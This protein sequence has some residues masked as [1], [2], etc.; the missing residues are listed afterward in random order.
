M[1]LL[2]RDINDKY[3]KLPQVNELRQYL[4]K[5]HENQL[6]RNIIQLSEQDARHE[7]KIEMVIENQRGMQFFGIPLFSKNSLIPI[8]DPSNYQLL[9]GG[10][11]KLIDNNLI[12]F[13]LPDINWEWFWGSW[14]VLMLN[15]VDDQGWAYSKIFFGN[16]HWKGKYY[17]GN[18]VRRRIWIRVRRREVEEYDEDVTG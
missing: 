13:P 5:D 4:T 3:K 16:H 12:N 17:F 14:Y 18:C 1:N 15:D 10:N 9:T 11:L 8:I 6:F 2:D 7:Y